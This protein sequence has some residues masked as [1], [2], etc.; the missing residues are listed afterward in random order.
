MDETVEPESTAQSHRAIEI[1]RCI[2]RQMALVR[3][4]ELMITKEA[5]KNM[6]DEE[7]DILIAEKLGWTLEIGKRRRA[8]YA[9]WM[10]PMGGEQ[11]VPNYSTVI[12]DA[13]KVLTYIKSLDREV[14]RQFAM[15]LEVTGAQEYGYLDFMDDLD[16]LAPR[17]IC[18]AA[19][20]A[21]NSKTRNE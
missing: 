7:L 9:Q 18:C 11:G 8:P 4:G 19:I 3:K 20:A 12:S 16:L 14:Q 10:S 15:A 17:N 13:W 5:C 21:L 2:L 6:S 1:G